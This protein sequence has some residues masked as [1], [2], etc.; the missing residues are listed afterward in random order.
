MKSFVAVFIVA[1]MCCVCSQSAYAFKPE[2]FIFKR[3]SACEGRGGSVGWFGE[4][5]RCEKCGG[6]GKV[7]SVWGTILVVA[8]GV[9]TYNKFFK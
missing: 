8:F 6:D 3:C 7:V 4:R 5:V 2:N 1:I 9:Y